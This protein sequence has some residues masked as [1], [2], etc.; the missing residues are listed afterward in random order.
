MPHPGGA[1]A[2]PRR[3]AGLP[4]GRRAGADPCARRRPARRAIAA[5]SSSR[6]RRVCSGAH[7]RGERDAAAA[8]RAGRR[9]TPGGRRRGGGRRDGAR[10]GY[11][12]RA[13]GRRVRTP[14]PR[15]P[16]PRP[17]ARSSTLATHASVA[18]R[19]HA[20]RR[21]AL[22]LRARD[23]AVP[24]RPRH[25]PGGACRPTSRR[26]SPRRRCGSPSRS[27]TTR[28]TASRPITRGPA[29]AAELTARRALQRAHGAPAAAL[30]VL[31][32]PVARPGLELGQ[33]GLQLAAHGR[34]PVGHLDRRAGLDVARRRRRA[35]R[36]PS[37]ARRAGGR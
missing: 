6:P 14:L 30:L 1:R 3:R 15:A 36:A 37:C 19:T 11:A 10:A 21:P 27:R 12:R 13:G 5:T 32:E 20:G 28:A 9:R 35:P 25:R 8:A 26:C 18:R 22:A 31:G 2:R 17:A 16:R 33:R 23:G 7:A 4:G 29:R 34:E 24:A